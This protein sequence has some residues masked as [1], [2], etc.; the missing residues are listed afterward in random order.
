MRAAREA[1]RPDS[2]KYYDIID[3]IRNDHIKA[4]SE[5][6]QDVDLLQQYLESVDIEREN[7]AKILEAAQHLGEVSSKTQDKIVATGEKLSCLYMT[8]LLHQHGIKAK[9]VDLSDCAQID[10][11]SDDLYGQLTR[12]FAAAILDCGDAVPVITGFFGTIPNGVL[13]TFGRGYTD[14]CAALVAVSLRATELQIWKEVDGIF[15]ADPRKVPTASLLETVT[16]AEA[17]E[18]TFYGSEVVH[19]STMD[20]AI[21]ASI[22]IRIKNV[23]NPRAK[24]TVI[25]PDA[26]DDADRQQSILKRGIIRGRPYKALVNGKP[27]SI[28]N[29]RGP[30]RPTAVTVKSGITV[31]NIHSRQRTRAHGFL[32][33]IFSVLDKH[34]LS[35]DLISSSEVNV[36]LALH[37]EVALLANAKPDSEEMLMECEALRGA[38]HDLGAWGDVIQVPSM[39]I[40][41]LVGRQLREMTGISGRFFSVLCQ[42]GI[43]I[44]MIS[45]GES[46]HVI[47]LAVHTEF[48]RR[49]RNQHFLCNRSKGSRPGAQCSAHCPLHISRLALAFGSACIFIHTDILGVN[50]RRHTAHA[51]R[52][53]HVVPFI[54]CLVSSVRLVS[55]CF[56]VASLRAQP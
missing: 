4:G 3:I 31:L 8:T 40:V 56:S 1:T 17:A 24:G 20:Q 23:M 46:V 33:S 49:E 16:P 45:Q 48:G 2:R 32:M 52:N 34:K 55:V 47:L 29:S 39:A 10:E 7:L 25:W 42:E 6:I 9:L 50:C 22:P 44:E 21:R 36:S 37:T 35:V 53:Q 43:N 51:Y 26:I 18:L 54:F 28:S 27:R 41:S 30:K 11:S 38:V 5:T 15:T 14:L 13:D 12:A 19:P